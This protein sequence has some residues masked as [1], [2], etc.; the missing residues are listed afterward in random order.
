LQY[1]L[2]WIQKEQWLAEVE[3]KPHESK[4]ESDQG[5]SGHSHSSALFTATVLDIATGI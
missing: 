1:I 2:V 5:H 3:L 4:E